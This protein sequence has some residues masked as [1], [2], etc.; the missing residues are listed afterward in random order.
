MTL[1]RKLAFT[2]AEI[3]VSIA[4]IGGISAGGY[5]VMRN[6][7]QSSNQVKLEQDV[8]IV[9]NAIRTYEVNGGKLAAGISG[10]EALVKI[11]R[12]SA[13]LRK[14]AG[15]KGSAIDPRMNLRYQTG[16]EASQGGK[17]AYWD[18]DERQFWISD[19]GDEP[20]VKEFYLGAL[21]P[22]LPLITN[23]DG[24][25]TNPNL[26]DRQTFGSFA[27]VDSWVWDYDSNGSTPRSTPSNVITSNATISSSSGTIDQTIIALA[28][29]RF[30]I[31]GGR[32]DLSWYPRD[33]TLTPA[34]ST[35][36]GVSEI[37]YIITGGQWQ[38]YSAP[39]PIS[40]PGQTV[41]AKSVALDL[42]HYSDSA[43]VMNNYSAMRS[44]GAPSP[45]APS[46]RFS[47]PH[48]GFSLPTSTTF[49][50]NLSGMMSSSPIGRGTAR[51]LTQPPPAAIP[52]FPSSPT[53]IPAKP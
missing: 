44:S 34:A 1:Y 3:L 43:E 16:G 31:A 40:D 25:V 51:V 29:P 2:L 6:V 39:I 15:L 5:V 20:G 47:R 7:S 38:K 14:N 13:D 10:D 48:H 27:A 45:A 30:S 23:A 18:P 9:N 17:R 46:L 24:T 19:S 33:L 37:Y 12:Q 50:I 11:R 41:V 49:P 52:G 36:A 26:D 32:F 8:R 35:P 4:V 28:P 42:D 21:P 53:A 22:P